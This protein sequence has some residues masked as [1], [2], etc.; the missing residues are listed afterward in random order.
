M[1]VALPVKGT[2][3]DII[4]FERTVNKQIERIAQARSA[5]APAARELEVLDELLDAWRDPEYDATLK[6][7]KNLQANG[8]GGS[9]DYE[10]QVFRAIMGLAKRQNLLDTMEEAYL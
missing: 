3:G 8:G 1:A 6:A 5:D 10:G 4:N 2:T 9:L 7:L